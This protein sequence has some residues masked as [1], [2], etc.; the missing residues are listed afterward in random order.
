MAECELLA[1]C[2]FFQ[3]YQDTLNLACRGFIKSY[4]RGPMMDNCLRK[5]YRAE[6]GSPPDPDMLPTGQ[7]LPKDYQQG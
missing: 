6:H 3:K 5:K 7:M 2:G 4:C 1:N